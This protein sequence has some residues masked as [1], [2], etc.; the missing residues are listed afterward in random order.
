VR[1]SGPQPTGIYFGEQTVESLMEGMRR[2]EARE[3]TFKPSQA[4]RWAAEFS[5]PV[6]LERMRTFIL[7]RVPAAAAEMLS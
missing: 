2:F 6:F 5:T 4:Q 1:G 7:S 3:A